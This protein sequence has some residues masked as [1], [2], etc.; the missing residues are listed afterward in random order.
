MEGDNGETSIWSDTSISGEVQF[1]LSS[2]LDVVDSN[3]NTTDN[4]NIADSTLP[5]EMVEFLEEFPD[6]PNKW[7]K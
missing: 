2:M 4:D 1:K 5:Y 6:A 7:M 3:S